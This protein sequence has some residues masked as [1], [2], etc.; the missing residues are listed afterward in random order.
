MACPICGEALVVYDHRERK[1]ILPDGEIITF[2]I[3]RFKCPHCN[4]LHNGLLPIM[5][6]YKHH[7]SASIQKVLDG[8]FADVVAEESTLNRW[9]RWF[10]QIKT[11][12]EG[13][14][15]AVEII[16]SGKTP[17]LLGKVSLLEI[18][19]KAYPDSWLSFVTRQLLNNGYAYPPGSRLLSTG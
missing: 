15:E 2:L 7:S 4:K 19:R 11:Y 16:K 13:A 1:V 18:H 8:N 14:L 3:P 12:L 10:Y 5:Q 6:P 17:N 9:M